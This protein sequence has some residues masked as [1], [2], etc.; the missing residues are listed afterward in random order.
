MRRFTSQTRFLLVL[1]AAILAMLFVTS[2]AEAKRSFLESFYARYVGSAGSRLDTCGLC[3]VNFRQNS[4]LNDYGRAFKAA[5]GTSDQ[6]GAFK[7]LDGDDPD[8]DTVSSADEIKDGF[9][10]GWNCKTIE[11][12]LNAP[13]YVTDYVDPTNPGCWSVTGPAIAATPLS[14]DFGTVEVGT[15][16]TLT[17]TISNEGDSDLTVSSLSITG[18]TDFAVNE[19]SSTTIFTVAPGASVD[20]LVDYTPGEAGDDAGVLEISSDDPDTSLLSVDIAGSGLV[21]GPAIAATPLSLNF[22]TVE[23]GSSVTLTT[24][25]S[26]KGD[27]DLTVSDLNKTGSI[28]FALNGEVPPTPFTVAPGTSVDVP[29]DYTPEEG[30][31]DAGTLEISS[32]DPDTSL[33][34]VSIAGSGLVPRTLVSDLDIAGFRAPKRLSLRREKPVK[35]KL[36]VVNKS[37]ISGSGTVTLTASNANEQLSLEQSEAA[38]SLADGE[39][40]TLIFNYM[41]TVSG[42]YTWTATISDDDPDD[43]A[44]TATTK[45]VP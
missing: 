19:V 31:N 21:P 5:G 39:R 6:T 8:K 9:L 27:S 3:H 40:A 17:T 28:D 22:G 14:L 20:V 32:D 25:I 13:S 24:T 34:S 10:P 7:A 11:L 35:M 43:D 4:A 36:V 18:S 37:G 30:G 15:N 29:V 41:P 44:A 12:A 45:V 42:I 38:I 16:M 2:N 1:L 33:L 26:N 23:V